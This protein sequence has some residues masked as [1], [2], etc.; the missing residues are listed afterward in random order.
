MVI[1]GQ[2]KQ[3]DMETTTEQKQR[4]Y[5]PQQPGE[6]IIKRISRVPIYC[7]RW[8]HT[9]LYNNTNNTHTSMHTCM[10]S[11]TQAYARTHTHTHMTVCHL[12]TK[13]WPIC[14]PLHCLKISDASNCPCAVS[15]GSQTH[16]TKLPYP[17]SRKDTLSAVWGW[18]EGRAMSKSACINPPTHT[19]MK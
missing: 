4:G 3:S 17:C 8:E 12:Q 5:V 1:S 2:Y 11:R 18:L 14:S 7:T 6:I 15:A 9:A 10:H 16:S 19:L 13:N